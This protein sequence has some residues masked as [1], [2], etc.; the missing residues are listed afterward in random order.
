MKHTSPRQWS[1][2]TF[3]PVITHGCALLVSRFGFL[4]LFFPVGRSRGLFFFV[5][6][7]DPLGDPGK[8]SF[9]PIPFHI[10][11]F[12]ISL[13]TAKL[14]LCPISALMAFHAVP[15]MGYAMRNR[16]K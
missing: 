5:F 9:R 16:M 3:G 15:H 2:L 7:L 12:V 13:S 8:K 4:F 10:C 6:F 11:V 14:Q 1:L